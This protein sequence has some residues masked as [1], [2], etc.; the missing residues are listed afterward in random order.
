MDKKKKM[1][2][3][4]ARVAYDL[5]EK[6]GR[7]HG[8]AEGDWLEA[9]RIVMER[10]MKEIEQEAGI[11]SATKKKKAPAKTETKTVKTSRKTAEKPSAAKAKKTPAK[12]TK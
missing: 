1:C 12:K 10:H 11:I 3:E 2:D 5:F 9:E 4:I 6:R 7:L 8:Y